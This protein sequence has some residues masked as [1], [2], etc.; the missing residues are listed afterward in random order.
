ME[1][2]QETQARLGRQ[3]RQTLTALQLDTYDKWVYTVC[4][5]DMLRDPEVPQTVA[6][7]PQQV[8]RLQQLHKELIAQGARRVAEVS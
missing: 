6:A 5:G 3:V 7:T 1:R 2:R 8:E 4:A